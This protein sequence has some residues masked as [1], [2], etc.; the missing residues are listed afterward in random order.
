M[1]GALGGLFDLTGRVAIVTGGSRGLGLQV[2]RALGEYGAS[3][4]IV[5]RRQTEL[6]AAVE[7]LAEAGYTASGFAVDLGT[8]AAAVELT[9]RV[10]AQFGR[11]DVLVNNAG[12]TW[13]APAEAYP[14]EGWNKV[15]DLNV[16][17]LFLL[18][19]AVA[20]T[21]FLPQGKGA[22]VNVASIEGLLG[23]HPDRLGTIAYNTAKG[24]VINMTR[25]LAAEWGPRGIRVN[26]LAPGFF[27]SKM[28]AA[29]LDAHGAEM[30]HQT[31]LGKLGGETDLMGPALLLASDAGGHITG[32]TIVVDG[33]MTIV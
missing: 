26:A 11:I 19:Q 25:A 3:L 14:L 8:P 29:T 1:S 23:H 13:G 27:P 17:G 32:Q 22:V 9:E 2:A 24:A 18:T 4:A 31:P 5:A 21:A 33:G 28:T 6:D 15:I 12:A 30:L 10:L 16:T 7:A 20:R